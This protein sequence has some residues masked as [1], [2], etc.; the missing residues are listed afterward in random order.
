MYK[1]EGKKTFCEPTWIRTKGTVRCTPVNYP[2]ALLFS[3]HKKFMPVFSP[4]VSN[5]VFF[6]QLCKINSLFSQL[7]ICRT[8]T[9]L[10]D[11]P[12]QM[13]QKCW[14]QTTPKLESVI[15]LKS[16][17]VLKNTTK[18]VECVGSQ[19]FFKL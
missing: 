17:P 16:K 5:A 8:I 13:F 11:K 10:C 9:Y 1:R 19:L 3:A 7:V 15:G 18:T 6:S 4:I 12:L 14:T 2:V